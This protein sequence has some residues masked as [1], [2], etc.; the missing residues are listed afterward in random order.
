MLDLKPWVRSE[1][2]RSQLD[3]DNTCGMESCFFL[4]FLP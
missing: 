3:Q 2:I 1:I 4:P